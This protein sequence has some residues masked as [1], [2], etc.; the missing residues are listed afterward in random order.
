MYDSLVCLIIYVILAA[1]A[2][3]TKGSAGT[4]TVDSPPFEARAA[5]PLCLGLVC[6]KQAVGPPSAG[7][8]NLVRVLKERAPPAVKEGE[9]R[10]RYR[11]VAL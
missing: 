2:L 4:S 10:R 5:M 11:S 6:S 9:E 3:R 1:T 7:V 8:L